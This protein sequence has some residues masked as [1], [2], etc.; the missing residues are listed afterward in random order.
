MRYINHVARFLKI[1][2]ELK[3]G[4]SGFSSVDESGVHI[5][6]SFSQEFHKD[7]CFVR[8]DKLWESYATTYGN[9]Y[10]RKFIFTWRLHP[11]Y[12]IHG[13]PHYSADE[14]QEFLLESEKEKLLYSCGEY[15]FY[16]KWDDITPPTSIIWGMK[17][18][19]C[20]YEVRKGKEVIIA[21]SVK[22]HL[23]EEFKFLTNREKS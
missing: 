9:Q 14:Q 1:T 10:I 3:K 18:G 22:K 5:F 2:E 20:F 7:A 23:H 21:T 8:K 16:W 17:N 15:D 6:K 13:R 4:A 19:P 11:N 12:C